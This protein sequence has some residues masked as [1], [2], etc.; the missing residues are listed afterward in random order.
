MKKG[1]TIQWIKRLALV[2]IGL[3]YLQM[4]STV[5]AAKLYKWVDKDGKVSYQDRPPPS[6]AKILQESSIDAEPTPAANAVDDRE[7]VLVYT[8]ENCD[9]CELLLLRL[10]QLNIPTQELSL[11]NREIQRQLLDGDNVLSA[12]TLRIGEKFVTD[13]SEQNLVSELRVGGYLDDPETSDPGELD[14]EEEAEDSEE[15]DELD[16]EDEDDE[17]EEDEEEE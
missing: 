15:E 9:S 8:V 11:I 2:C 5:L 6:E 14:D 16:D 17:D 12:P 10:N 1:F 7:P 13:I 3:V 4:S